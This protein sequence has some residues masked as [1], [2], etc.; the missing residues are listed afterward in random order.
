M[1]NMRSAY[2]EISVS[3]SQTVSVGQ[4][5]GTAVLL[6][7]DFS[8]DPIPINATD[9]FLQVVYRG[10]L[11]DEQDGI[12]V[13][14]VDVSE[15]TYVSILNHTDYVLKN[16]QWQIPAGSD[17]AAEPI[18]T[19]L[20]CHALWQIYASSTPGLP[21]GHVLRLAAL[22]DF[23]DQYLDK[24]NIGPSGAFDNFYG[25]WHG[26]QRQAV[27]EKARV[28][29]RTRYSMDEARCLAITWCMPTSMYHR[30]H[31]RSHLRGA[32]PLCRRLSQKI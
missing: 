10:P 27:D 6:T 9:L 23:T 29:T 18:T 22:R 13:G 19:S 2:Q 31:R 17:P 12:A 3:A 20:I 14:L 30:C 8:A 21:A 7:F 5:D 11:G 24:R 32:S 26:L 15:P 28:T 25:S 16:N 4:L 1:A